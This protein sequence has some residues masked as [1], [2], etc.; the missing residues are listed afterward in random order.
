MSQDLIEGDPILGIVSQHCCYQ[1][2]QL[3]MILGVGLLVFLEQ[4][5]VL[6]DILPR[7][8]VLVP[9]QLPTVEI[10]GLRPPRHLWREGPQYFLHHGQML[11]VVVG[12]EECKAQVQLKHDAAYTPDI[13]GL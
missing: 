1:V 12:L 2:K 7:G 5:A 4:L 11:P 3:L 8:A 6:P 9:H 10:F 13:T